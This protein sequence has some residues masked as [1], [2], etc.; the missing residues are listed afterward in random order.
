MW[1]RRLRQEDCFLLAWCWSRSFATEKL[2]F[3]SQGLYEGKT[4]VDYLSSA[5]TSTYSSTVRVWIIGHPLHGIPPLGHGGKSHRV[6]VRTGIKTSGHIERRAFKL[7]SER[8]QPY[9]QHLEV[10]TIRVERNVLYLFIRKISVKV[11]GLSTF[12][13]NGY[14]CEP[15]SPNLNQQMTFIKPHETQSS[16]MTHPKVPNPSVYGEKIAFRL[17]AASVN[18]RL[19]WQKKSS[20]SAIRMYVG[21]RCT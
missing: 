18:T 13:L 6:P 8:D 5:K 3:G 16:K 10:N 19:V 2:V 15:S 9:I 17:G 11:S 14:G 20:I 21:I 1:P 4:T 12:T 7:V